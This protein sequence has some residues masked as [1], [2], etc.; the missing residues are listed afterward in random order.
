MIGSKNLAV[1]SV[2]VSKVPGVNR[3]ATMGIPKACLGRDAH[4]A[5][6]LGEV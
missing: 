5:G 1:V 6:G 3:A 2:E 4:G